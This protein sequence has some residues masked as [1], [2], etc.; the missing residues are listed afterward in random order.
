M[1]EKVRFGILAV[2]IWA[3]SPALADTVLI[4][5]ANSGIGLEFAKQYAADGWDVIATHRRS[6]TP[7]AL[8]D[9]Q[10]QY[11]GLRIERIDVTDPEM[12]AA[13]AKNLEGVP[14][15]VVINNAG[16]VGTFEDTR[17]HFGSFDFELFEQF[18][19]VNTAGPLRIAQA[20]YPNVVASKQKKIV[21]ISSA[22]GS[23]S[24]VKGGLAQGIPIVNRYWYNMSKTAL[25]MSFIQLAANTA[26]DGVS[27]AVYHPGLVR[28]ERT[29]NYQL[30][31]AFKAM[32]LDVDESVGALRQRFAEL[33][34]ETSGGFYAF[35]GR[36]MPW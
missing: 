9:L 8:A 4:T 22:A 3:G 15:D 26:K 20:F 31:E 35:D 32:A 14:I 21:A 24:T 13:A 18:M 7:D 5:G 10:H 33:N 2:L 11:P 29:A 27:V 36:T 6:T 19:A 30:P 28:V 23:Q 16:I 17:Q 12:I 1:C 25:N 34:S